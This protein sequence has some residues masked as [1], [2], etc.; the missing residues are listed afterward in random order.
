MPNIEIKAKCSNLNLA[1]EVALKLATE[2]LGMDYQIDTY[3]HTLEGRLKLRESSLK[4][5][6]LI[7]YFRDNLSGPKKSQYTFLTSTE[8]ELARELL[9]KALGV[10]QV[11]DK[12][13]EIFLIDNVRVHLD[14][15]KGLGTF[16][17]FEAVYKV[18]SKAA[19]E[20]EYQKVCLLMQKFNIQEKDL[21]K[22]SYRELSKS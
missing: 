18:E 22:E 11:I 16:I 13:R 7:P 12:M 5:A 9:G 3:F 2:C 19:E 21:L 8:P 14:Q 6:Y 20:I 10:S 17:E 15:V 4:G 1:R